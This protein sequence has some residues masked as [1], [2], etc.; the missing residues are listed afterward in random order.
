MNSNIINRQTKTYPKDWRK[1]TLE[2]VCQVR[3]GASPRPAGDPRYFGGDIPWIKIADATA[4]PGRWLYRTKETVNEAGKEKSVFLKTGALILSNSGTTGHPKFLAMD[5]CIHD[6][7]LAFD[8]F[9]GIDQL[10]LF[11]L[12]SWQTSYLTYIADG[13]VQKNLNTTLLKNLEIAL[14]PL[15]EQRAIAEILG[16]LDDKIELNR[17]MNATLEAIARALF[18]SWFVDF[19]PVY[20]NRGE[21]PTPLPAEVLALFPDT[22]TDSDLGPIPEGWE[23]G[24]LGNIAKNIR[25]SVHPE[26][27]PSNTPYIGLQHMP[28]QSIALSDWGDAEEVNSNKYQFQTEQILFGKLRPYFHKVGIAPV[29][30]ICSTDILVIVPKL[31]QWF[32]FVLELV[33][34][35]QFI[36]YT[37]AVS[38]GTRMPRTNWRNMSKYEVIKPPLTLVKTYNEM[39]KPLF[40]LIQQ[41][42]H[43][44]RTLAELRDTLLPRLISGELRVPEAIL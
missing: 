9:K 35:S 19:D 33:S 3:R 38:T 26:D 18:K 39:T 43:Q 31:E 8:N 37:T 21:R 36:D 23:V 11:Y 34:S 32:S 17:Q 5:G 28:Q 27:L 7:W 4:E 41:N 44:S 16:S 40:E 6:G 42:I 22:F 30:G 25:K 14:P 12:L 13:S 20:A 10:F 2:D 15:P 29:N 24:T 1:L